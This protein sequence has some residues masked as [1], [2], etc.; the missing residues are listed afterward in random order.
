VNN[1]TVV[2]LTLNEEAH[3][4]RCIRSVQPFA[5][6]VLVVDSGSTDRTR[7][8]SESLG[9]R[10]YENAWVSHAVQLNWALDHC[11]IETAWVMRLDADEYVTP[12]LARE[13]ADRLAGLEPEVTG[14]ELRRRVHFMGRWIRHGSYYPTVLLRLLRT[15]RGRCEDRWMDEHLQVDSGR[16]VTFDHDFVDDNL[17]NLTWWT[18]KHN[19]Y[20]TREAVELLDLR[21]GLLERPQGGLAG[22]ARGK[23]WLK[24]NVYARL[25]TGLRPILYFLYRY[26]LRL[27]FLD[28]F[29]GFVFHTLQGFWYRFLVDAK[30]YDIER[31]ARLRGV[32]A[33]SVLKQDYGMKV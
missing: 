10:W 9:A 31:R 24:R 11:P 1:V 29:E 22:Q 12:D 32:D 27:G 23:R 19:G 26:V 4:E 16:V 20:A 13:I 18:H 7:E 33:R 21:Y 25:P 3:L 15:G 5:G 28:G 14:V 17:H 30:V 8:I 2:I 6:Q